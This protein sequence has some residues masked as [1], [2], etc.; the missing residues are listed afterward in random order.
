MLCETKSAKVGSHLFTRILTTDGKDSRFDPVRGNPPFL[1]SLFMAQA[2]WVTLCTLP[3]SALNALPPATFKALSPLS[4]SLSA[5]GLGIFAFGLVF[6]VIADRQ[7]TQWLQEKKEKKHEEDFL[8]RGLWGKSRH[9][10]Y[11]GEITLWAGLATTGAAILASAPGLAALGWSSTWIN[12]LL[13]A[14]L[15]AAS[16]AASALILI[17]G[18]GVP[19]SETKYD[20]LYG[21]RKDYRQWRDNT[22][23][24]I[25]KLT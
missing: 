3:V 23:M 19:P 5:A 17:K 21:H 7:K 24:I 18:T 1:F 12:Q 20:K 13:M 11:F 10:N 25:P 15:C 16:P 9:P 6:E 22:P 4:A 2:A 8:T 14:S